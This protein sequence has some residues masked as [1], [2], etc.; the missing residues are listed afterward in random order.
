[1]ETITKNDGSQSSN[2]KYFALKKGEQP[3]Y[4]NIVGCRNPDTLAEMMNDWESIYINKNFSISVIILFVFHKMKWFPIF[5]FWTLKND[6]AYTIVQ[7]SIHHLEEKI[8][9]YNRLVLVFLITQ[10]WTFQRDV[11]AKMLILDPKIM[12]FPYLSMELRSEIFTVY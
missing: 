1:M 12:H 11:N 8:A 3:L 5:D 4:P 2:Q 9:F 10:V 6:R 7:Y